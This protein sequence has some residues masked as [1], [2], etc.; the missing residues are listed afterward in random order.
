MSS[1]PNDR[2]QTEVEE[3]AEREQYNDYWRDRDEQ[4]GVEHHIWE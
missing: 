4:D 2:E 3:Q 1:H